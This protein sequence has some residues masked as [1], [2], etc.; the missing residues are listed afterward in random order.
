MNSTRINSI[1]VRVEPGVHPVDVRYGE[2]I[3]AFWDKQVAANSTLFNGEF[4]FT[5]EKN[6]KD[7]VLNAVY[8]RSSFASFIYWRS[9]VTDIEGMFHIFSA[10]AMVSKENAILV[11][12]MAS[13]TANAGKEYIPAGSICD[14]DICEALV[15]F[16]YSMLREAKEETGIILEISQAK[17]FYTMMETKGVLAL[18]REFDT[19]LSSKALLARVRGNMRELEEDELDSVS[20]YSPGEV[21]ETMP[22]FL[23]DYQI[24]RLSILANSGK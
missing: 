12:K 20:M 1:D 19:G 5:V 17:P 13:H 2:E 11:G 18:I 8:R 3:A 9:H 22:Q 15:D 4:Y 23:Q 10:G 21:N 6:C 7:G 16:E 24:N 14:A